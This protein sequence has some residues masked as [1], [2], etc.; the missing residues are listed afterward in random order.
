M[1]RFEIRHHVYNLDALLVYARLFGGH[2]AGAV[3]RAL[4]RFDG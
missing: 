2:Y 1:R 4:A 3:E